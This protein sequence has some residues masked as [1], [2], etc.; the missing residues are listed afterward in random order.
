MNIKSVF[1]LEA[2]D[3]QTRGVAL[4]AISPFPARALLVE[5]T[6]LPDPFLRPPI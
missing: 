3:F 5:D 1:G 6:G 4:H 2:S